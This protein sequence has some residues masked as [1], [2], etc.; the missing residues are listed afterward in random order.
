M[1]S[2]N[3]GE[4]TLKPEGS[5]SQAKTLESEYSRQRAAL[6]HAGGRL[7]LTDLKLNLKLNLNL[8][9]LLLKFAIY[10]LLLLF[11]LYL[12][13]TMAS[14]LGPFPVVKTKKWIFDSVEPPTI[15]HSI[16]CASAFS[17]MLA[18]EHEEAWRQLSHRTIT[19]IQTKHPTTGTI[20]IWSKQ[21]IISFRQSLTASHLSPPKLSGLAPLSELAPPRTHAIVPLNSPFCNALKNLSSQPVIITFCKPQET[22]FIMTLGDWLLEQTRQDRINAGYGEGWV[23]GAFS[24][25]LDIRAGMLTWDYWAGQLEASNGLVTAQFQ[26]DNDICMRWWEKPRDTM[27]PPVFLMRIMQQLKYGLLFNV[28]TKKSAAAGALYVQGL[29][30]TIMMGSLHFTN[31]ICGRS[32]KQ[33]FAYSKAHLKTSLN[34]TEEYLKVFPHLGKEPTGFYYSL[35]LTHLVFDHGKFAQ[36]V[37]DYSKAAA[38]KKNP[39]L[40]F[41]LRAINPAISDFFLCSDTHGRGL[42][43]E[44]HSE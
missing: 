28:I 29:F 39:L 17:S 5:Y 24:Q 38:N 32:I 20:P 36:R 21:V 27:D 16:A 34:V 2:S 7:S 9:R 25:S 23:P 37:K 42:P 30:G 35:P 22:D 43:A 10:L 18:N 1:S 31:Q 3:A 6:T 44:T 15:Y 19:D 12:T 26:A 40:H 13:Q 41:S 33:N 4:H 8:N 14:A 11:G